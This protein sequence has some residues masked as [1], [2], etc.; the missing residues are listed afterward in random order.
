MNK[1]IFFALIMLGAGFVV[2]TA[3]QQTD[4]EEQEH[5]IEV[6]VAENVNLFIQE[7][8]LACEQKAHEEATRRAMAKLAEMGKPMPPPAPRPTRP[9]GET[10]APQEPLSREQPKEEAK[11]ETRTR[12]GATTDTSGEGERTRTGATRVEEGKEEEKPTQRTRTGAT[13]GGGN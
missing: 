11:P 8:T 10:A 5:Q 3:F 12:T 9:A 4:R 2:W 7:Q 6:A 13:G 1:S